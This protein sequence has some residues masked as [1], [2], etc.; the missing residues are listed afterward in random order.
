MITQLKAE[1]AALNAQIKEI[2]DECSHPNLARTTEY[3]EG[4][5]EI[6]TTVTSKSNFHICSLC[7]KRW[8]EDIPM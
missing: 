3:S 5:D 6:G 1:I 4:T 2:Q 8:S 7:E